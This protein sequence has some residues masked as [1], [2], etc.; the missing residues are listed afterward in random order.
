M[1]RLARRTFL[2]GLI[3]GLGRTARAAQST[4]TRRL[5]ARRLGA[6]LD[7][8][9]LAVIVVPEEHAARLRLEL[10]WDRFLAGAKPEE[11]VDLGL[12][13]RTAATR[14]ELEGIT[15]GTESPLA[16]DAALVL[17]EAG[18]AP[19]ALS[20]RELPPGMG[21]G[22][23]GSRTDE[24][25]AQTLARFLHPDRASV[26]R[27]RARFEAVLSREPERMREELTRNLAVAWKLREEAESERGQRR[28]A[29]LAKAGRLVSAPECGRPKSG[30]GWRP[31]AIPTPRIPCAGGPCG[32]GYFSASGQRFVN[33][34]VA[35][36]GSR[37]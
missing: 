18:L 17:L 21:L 8:M 12:V 29:L 28:R 34:W 36:E 19:A 11:L 23:R 2:G 20:T 24:R 13:R 14:A 25:L 22:I 9:A 1:S 26:R 32:T 31:P 30:P 27:R 10:A 37:N 6:T 3:L 35:P 16:A 7:G 5:A 15:I 33:F 4:P